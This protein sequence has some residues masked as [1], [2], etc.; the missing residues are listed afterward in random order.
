MNKYFYFFDLN[1]VLIDRYPAEISKYLQE[2]YH[3][4]NFIF[5]YSEKYGN[6][7]PIKI[8][9]GG[10]SFYI[11]DLDPPK[12][13]TLI[14]K[15]P[16]KSLTT[17]AQRIPDMLI[18]SIFNK[19]NIPTFIVQHGLWSDKLDRIALIKLILNKLSKFMNYIKYTISLSRINKIPIIPTLL[20]LYKFFLVENIKIPDTKFLNIDG[21]RAKKA[22]VFDKSWDE[23]YLEKY[24]YDSMD[25]IYIGNPDFLI[26]KEKDLNIKEDAVCYICQSLVEDG[27]YLLKD[28][29]KFLKIL[30][31]YVASKKKLYIKLHPRS[32]KEY[33]RILKPNKNIIFTDDFPICEYYI[34]HYSGMLAVAK[35]CSDNILIW[36][37]KNHHMPNYFY[38][39]AS[40]ITDNIT[41]LR[42]FIEGKSRKNQKI[43]YPK[44][45]NEE[46]MNFKPIKLIADNLVSLS[47]K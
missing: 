20:E 29:V 22:F 23:Y 1:E 39:F 7:T 26:L 41:E 2:N 31:D 35:Q 47:V 45:S 30:N 24:G 14:G 38:Q 21:L 27:R 3:T 28:F 33:Y 17:I 10:K 15:Y 11:S 25:L 46:L 44:L 40:V 8:P 6:G 32:K 5:I 42:N 34:A 36:N 9:K 18:L 4:N 37:L 16:P 43:S 12:I 13:N 19:K